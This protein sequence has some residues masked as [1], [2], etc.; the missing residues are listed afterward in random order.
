MTED[1]H[2]VTQGKGGLFYSFPRNSKPVPRSRQPV[3]RRLI[4]TSFSM[5]NTS[6]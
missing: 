5:S 6:T 1:D 4:D 3:R 2:E